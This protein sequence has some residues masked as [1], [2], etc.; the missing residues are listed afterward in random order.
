[1][2]SMEE[3]FHRDVTIGFAQLEKGQ[4]VT[5]ESKQAFIALLRKPNS[6]TPPA[7]NVTAPPA[8]MPE[9]WQPVAGA[10]RE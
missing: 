8:F 3:T 9:A 6:P 5:V 4:T 1:M 2:S 10:S 7:H